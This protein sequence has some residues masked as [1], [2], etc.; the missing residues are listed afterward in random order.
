MAVYLIG[1]MDIDDPQLYTQYVEECGASLSTA[2]ATVIILDDHPEIVEGNQPGKRITGLRFEDRD[3][4]YRW[5]NSPAYKQA[6]AIRHRS[7]DTSFL[8]LVEAMD[9]GDTTLA[10]PKGRPS[11]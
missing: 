6:R 3:A 4:F 11:I 7:A 1:A 8:M 9:E 10:I 2:N 5:Y